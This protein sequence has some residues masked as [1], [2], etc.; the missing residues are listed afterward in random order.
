VF[1]STRSASGPRGFSGLLSD[2]GSLRISSF[3]ELRGSL[4]GQHSGGL[5]R[6]PDPVHEDRLAVVDELHAANSGLL[7]HWAAVLLEAESA[8]L[9]DAD[10]VIRLVGVGDG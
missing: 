2:A 10:L 4:T 5:G 1:K 9:G 8:G 3:V 7:G 6:S